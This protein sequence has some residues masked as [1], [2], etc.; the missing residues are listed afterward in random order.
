MAHY[1]FKICIFYP[2]SSITAE[3]VHEPLEEHGVVSGVCVSVHIVIWY[4]QS[5]WISK[6]GKMIFIRNEINSHAV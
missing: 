4:S 3:I 5:L 6:M 1:F 2:Y